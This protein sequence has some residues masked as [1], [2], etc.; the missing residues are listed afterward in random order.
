MVKKSD[1][2]DDKSSKD[3]KSKDNGQ[4]GPNKDSK[5]APAGGDPKGKPT[6]KGKI[7]KSRDSF[8][9]KRAIW[10]A[11]SP[12]YIRSLSIGQLEALHGQI[13]QE[14]S[15]RNKS[16]CTITP[17]GGHVQPSATK[18][19]SGK[20][21]VVKTDG[22][23]KA[24]TGNENPKKG[25]Q[26]DGSL[27]FTENGIHF[28]FPAT[29]NGLISSQPS[30]GKVHEPTDETW[31]TFP[32]LRAMYTRLR[33]VRLNVT[34]SRYNLESGFIQL[35]GS[36]V[37]E[38][39]EKHPEK[40][41]KKRLSEDGIKALG[42][43]NGQE[44]V[45]NLFR[46]W[47]LWLERVKEVT[48]DFRTWIDNQV[49]THRFPVGL[50]AQGSVLSYPTDLIEMRV[51]LE[52]PTFTANSLTLRVVGSYLSSRL[53]NIDVPGR[54][55]FFLLRKSKPD[56]SQMDTSEDQTEPPPKKKKGGSG[57]PEPSN[58]K[59]KKEK[60]NSKKPPPKPKGKGKGKRNRDEDSDGSPN[61]GR[62]RRAGSTDSTG[63]VRE[64]FSG[65]KLNSPSQK[66]VGKERKNVSFSNE[67]NPGQ[68]HP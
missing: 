64:L 62:E 8:L 18:R 66:N 31:E 14:L 53:N 51:G 49:V 16:I 24:K 40:F 7:D 54:E 9:A 48:E 25:S 65:V 42:L 59:G 46:Q 68:T 58:P 26:I 19:P 17:T 32:E 43:G 36:T 20:N 37:Q 52:S 41:P 12:D 55:R 30:S 45:L 61:P 57:N 6:T 1:K 4:G 35:A 15:R 33:M 34:V 28:A 27:S 5:N 3:D 63:G 11:S 22:K 10:L 44:E 50:S 13:A 39:L 67:E 23:N 38:A 47:L 29:V 56:E 2:P 21:Q 60:D